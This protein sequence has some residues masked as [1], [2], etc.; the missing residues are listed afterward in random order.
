MGAAAPRETRPAQRDAVW[1]QLYDSTCSMSLF[2]PPAP[3]R[4][5]DS[6]EELQTAGFHCRCH[7]L[8]LTHLRTA[9]RKEEEEEEGKKKPLS[10]S[11]VS[12]FFLRACARMT[13]HFLARVISKGLIQFALQAVPNPAHTF[14]HI[15]PSRR[16]TLEHCCLIV[17]YCQSSGLFHPAVV[18][19]GGRNGYYKKNKKNKTSQNKNV[20][21]SDCRP[22]KV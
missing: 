14:P 11:H 16:S 9:K 18:G 13:F 20:A 8:C 10:H 21:L 4:A 5:P 1:K 3:H 15:S 22:V 19:E 6:L 17:F 7:D 12:Y 2:A